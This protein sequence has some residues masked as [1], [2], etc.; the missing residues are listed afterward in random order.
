MTSITFKNNRLRYLDQ[1]QLPLKE[2]WKECSSARQGYAA[3]K[4]LQVRGAPLIGVFAAYCAWIEIQKLSER[5]DKKFLKNSLAIIDTLK[6]CRP[7]AINLAWA[8]E[9]MRTILTSSTAAPHVLKRLLRT[10]AIAIHQ[11]DIRLCRAMAEFGA[12]LVKNNDTILTHCNAGALA[13]AGMGTAV[14]VI[15][16]SARRYKN[17][18]VYADETR[19]LLQGSRLT[20]WELQ[21]SGVEVTVICDNMAAYLM[22]LGK[23]NK[24]FVGAD[25]ITANGDVANKIGTYGVAVSAKHHKI[26]FYVVAPFSTFDLTLQKGSQIPI[27]ERNHEEVR[28]ILRKV[29][30]APKKIQTWNPAFD[31]TPHE[32]ITA[33]ITDRGIIKPPFNKNITAALQR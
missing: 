27:E 16:E 19:P 33:I 30:T 26:P 3:I 23:I 4:E 29:A 13:T 11:E 17:I 32:L 12:S 15:Y 25:R 20:A 31:V 1:T 14:G 10:E 28:T 6:T 22:Q 5:T 8:L 18:K 21:K 2:A 7:T 24:I 9:R